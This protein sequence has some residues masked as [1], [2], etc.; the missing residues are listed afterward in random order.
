[1]TMDKIIASIT[2]TNSIKFAELEGRKI[3]PS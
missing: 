3:V 2:E 1:M